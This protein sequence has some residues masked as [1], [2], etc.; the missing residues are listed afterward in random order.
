MSNKEMSEL[1]KPV[2]WFTDD[3]LTDKSATTYS[4]EM[5]QR[6]RDKPWFVSNLYSQEY[7]SA[8][9]AELEAKDKRI[10]ELEAKL[11][12]REMQPVAWQYRYSSLGLVGEW[13]TVQ[14]ELLCNT[15]PEY[16]RRPIFTAPPAVPD[17]KL[18]SPI[19]PDG[20]IF[21]IDHLLDV[22]GSRGGYS[23]VECHDAREKVERLL[24]AA[25][26]QGQ[27]NE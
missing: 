3:Y 23:A 17:Y 12:I 19:I 27:G 16:E 14:D 25:P 15:R 7:V 9:L 5:A 22:D 11:A 10:A 26:T 4:E 8:L 18:N 13:K 24:A 1:S 6:W 20:L 2:A 21:A